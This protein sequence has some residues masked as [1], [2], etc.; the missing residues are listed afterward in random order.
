ML[1]HWILARP[2]DFHAPSDRQSGK[3]KGTHGAHW[4]I[5]QRREQS[6]AHQACLWPFMTQQRVQITFHRQRQVQVKQVSDARL[7]RVTSCLPFTHSPIHFYP[8]HWSERRHSFP[9][10]SVLLTDAS[11]DGSP[12]LEKEREKQNASLIV[13]DSLVKWQI[14]R[15][16]PIALIVQLACIHPTIMSLCLSSCCCFFPYSPMSLPFATHSLKYFLHLH[17]SATLYM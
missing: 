17:V 4:F 9:L 2:S 1:A 15:P 11:A 3:G 5:G 8:R 6:V 16:P 7:A 10:S 13:T 12:E 14:T